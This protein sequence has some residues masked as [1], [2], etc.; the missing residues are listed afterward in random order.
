MAKPDSLFAPISV[1]DPR[2]Y[3]GVRSF[4]EHDQARFFGRSRATDELL[5]RVLSVRLLLQFAPSGA[6]KTS[7]LN[8]GLFP[9]LRPHNYFPF[10]IRLNQDKESLTQATAR[11]LKDA[12][13][14][15]GLKEPVIPENVES[16]RALLAGTQLWSRDLLLLT[17]VLVFD[18]FEEVFTLRDEAFRRGFASEVGEL[19]RP[20]SHRR[21]SGQSPDAP[22]KEPPAPDV[23]III[24]LREE[25]LGKLEEFSSSIPDL[26]HERLRL[27]SLNT[28]EAKEAIVE[29]AKFEGDAW[30]SPPFE[31][32]PACLDS[33]I[34]FIDG[35][36]D[37]AKVIEPLTLQLVCQQAEEIAIKRRGP[38]GHRTKLGFSDFGG[39][40]GVERLVQNYFKSELDKLGGPRI[41]K[42]AQAMFEQ[43]LLDPNGK[44]LMLE[45]GEIERGY[46]L[47]AAALN[48]L[49]DSRLLRREPRNES[50]FYE[51]S[52]DRLTEAIDKQRKPKLPAWV[53]PTIAVGAVLILV[54]VVGAVFSVNNERAQARKQ[55]EAAEAQKEAV[56]EVLLEE[57]LVSRLREAGLLD[58]L[59]PI[60][61]RAR[62][63]ESSKSLARALSLRQQGEMLRTRETLKAARE[64]FTESLA[65][66]IAVM[67]RQGG[68]DP[69]LLAERARTLNDLGL[70]L[71]DSGE[72][73]QAELRYTQSVQ[74]WDQVLKSEADLDLQK[75]LEALDT[76]LALGSL[77]QRMGSAE[78]AEAE[79]TTA[80]PIALKVLRAAYDQAQRH[81]DGFF[82]LGH[83]MQ[84]YA[85]VALRLAMVSRRE[86]EFIGALALARE[87]LRLRP[88]SFQAR[89][90]V[91][92]ASAVSTTALLD[93]NPS[94][95]LA[96]FRESE[97]QFDELTQT[98]PSNLL[99]Q[100]EREALRVLFA[101]G[102]ATCWARRECA[103]TLSRETLENAEISA[104]QSIGS[105]RSLAGRDSENRS[106][107]TDI[108][109]ALET[110]ANLLSAL[111]SPAEALSLLDEAL[112]ITSKA[113]V[114]VQD[115]ENRLRV[116][117]LSQNKARLLEQSGKRPDVLAAVAALDVSLAEVG[118]MPDNLPAVAQE[119]LNT[120]DAKIALLKKLGQVDAAKQLLGSREGL[121]ALIGK[122]RETT[123]DRALALNAEG[124]KLYEQAAKLPGAAAAGEFH[125]AVDKYEL[126]IQEYPLEYTFWTNLKDAYT[127]IAVVEEELDS[128][129][130]AGDASSPEQVKPDGAGKPHADEREAA[131]RSA[132]AAAWMARVLSSEKSVGESWKALYEARRSLALF[133]RDN[134][135]PKE[136]LALATQ[137]VLD[138]DE[139]AR[140]QPGSTVALF[141]LADAN[142]GLG[143][144][145]WE[146]SP[147][148]DG[149]ADAL[150]RGL[151]HG[152]QLAK[153][154]PTKAEHQN[155]VGSF[156]RELANYLI[157]AQ[158]K[159][160]AVEEYKLA[161]RA[162]RE[163]LR[164]A[165]G[166]DVQHDQAQ[167]CLAEL[168]TEGYK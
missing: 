94:F 21:A 81:P 68:S 36:S 130:A 160:A 129:A 135:R 102:V 66:L 64:K 134:K 131:L 45:Q 112:V 3:P 109:W 151:A 37:K 17:P 41:R 83:A 148:D 105:F 127:Q 132:F 46:G 39:L 165:K 28:E 120:I 67:T 76:R 95:P 123:R 78:R 33:L 146:S 126:A 30:S 113:V 80:A 10:I 26:F 121:Q 90:Q 12:A 52:H 74:I 143:M 86:S 4:E 115:V 98:D 79:L 48:K 152:D 61:E 119:R 9:K 69:R 124:V 128:G 42:Q 142:V 111:G 116:V 158:Q 137:G 149:W 6:G 20:Q 51:I 133:L 136:V 144:T 35:A 7:L 103:K 117:E 5:L 50:V 70:V 100:R 11:A 104:L 163:A 24:S 14:R 155:W 65:V 34:D 88:L 139:Y 145:R 54:V 82:E 75:T 167:S 138:A 153:R 118:R 23:K 108:V 62:I 106:L 164:L 161:L 29:P 44:R 19:S 58:A 40:A 73:A 114:D 159:E 141:L 97:R 72:V 53:R 122:P 71:T 156:R 107:Q 140:L 99:Q 166:T 43:G 32:E 125:R 89:L 110:R 16:L 15:N 168:A 77:R 85:D 63:D 60:L 147:R 13:A 27:S 25:Y 8:A 56:V 47:D 31:L 91:G 93:S 18:Q 1:D 55:A 96:L 150:R 59:A 38:P 22:A 2:R 84:I 49:V 57:G 92:V 101:E 157:D 162:C 87:S 154:E